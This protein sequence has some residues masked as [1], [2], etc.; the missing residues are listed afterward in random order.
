MFSFPA[1][2]PGDIVFFKEAT[3]EH[4]FAKNN[5]RIP[6]GCVFCGAHQPNALCRRSIYEGRL[7]VGEAWAGCGKGREGN[8]SLMIGAEEDFPNGNGLLCLGPAKQ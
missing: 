5:L 1:L 6:I 8:V 2:D 3:Q 7:I 4:K